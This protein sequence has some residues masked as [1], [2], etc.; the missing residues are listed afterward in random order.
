[1]L[2]HMEPKICKK[3]TNL[4][5]SDLCAFFHI[6]ILESLELNQPHKLY[7]TKVNRNSI[8]EFIKNELLK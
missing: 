8:T 5:F 7:C 6:Y 1:M 2:L 3:E 4:A